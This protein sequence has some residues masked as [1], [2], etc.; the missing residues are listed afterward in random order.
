MTERSTGTFEANTMKNPKE[1]CKVVITQ[2]KK[3]GDAKANKE[4]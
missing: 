2:N 4:L 3:K 1:E